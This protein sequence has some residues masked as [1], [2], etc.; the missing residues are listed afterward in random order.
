MEWIIFFLVSSALW[1][2]L[3]SL[4]SVGQ[5][6][7][8]LE[9]SWNSPSTPFFGMADTCH[10]T[11]G[12][13]IICF[14]IAVN[15][16]LVVSTNLIAKTLLIDS[17]TVYEKDLIS[18]IKFSCPPSLDFNSKLENRLHDP[19]SFEFISYLYWN[20]QLYLDL[21]QSQSFRL[22]CWW[23]PLL[24]LLMKYKEKSEVLWSDSTDASAMSGQTLSSQKPLLCSC[25]FIISTTLSTAFAC[26][27][28]S[29]K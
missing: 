15:R 20:G 19:L 16:L 24:S 11:N 28:D 29:T 4:H 13:H 25:I 7:I 14:A 3:L 12:F 21:I 6:T 2:T 9:Y 23:F 5:T 18:A 10:H 27:W 1:L 22:S 8:S 26:W 17:S